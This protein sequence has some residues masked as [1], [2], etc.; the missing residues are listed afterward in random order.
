MVLSDYPYFL[1]ETLLITYII[2]LFIY[3]KIFSP[4]LF[5]THFS[6]SPIKKNSYADHLSFGD[7]IGRAH[8]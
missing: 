1:Y 6:H 2:G 4:I 7:Q 3:Q 8:V 5:S